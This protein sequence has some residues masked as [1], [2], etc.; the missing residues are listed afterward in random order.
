MVMTDLLL[1]MGHEHLSTTMIYANVALGRV[2]E[3]FQVSR[4]SIVCWRAVTRRILPSCYDDRWTGQ[5]VNR[6]DLTYSAR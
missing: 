5:N 4:R 1:L 3:R 6:R 2:R